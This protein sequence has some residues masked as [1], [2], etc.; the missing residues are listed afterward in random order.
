M[1]RH[2]DFDPINK[3]EQVLPKAKVLPTSP[4]LD[5]IIKH[6]IPLYI[7]VMDTAD[8]IVTIHAT[9]NPTKEDEFQIKIA[10]RLESPLLRIGKG[11]ITDHIDFS[12]MNS[13][14]EYYENKFIVHS[15]SLRRKHQSLINNV[16]KHLDLKELK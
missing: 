4:V 5:G 7:H 3:K 11:V 13:K 16:Y 14:K 1:R 8:S 2:T 6:I 9:T 10:P 15:R 12:L